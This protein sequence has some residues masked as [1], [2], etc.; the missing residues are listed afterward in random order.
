MTRDSITPRIALAAALCAFAI[1][2]AAEPEHTF[3]AT[4][5]EKKPF[6]FGGYAQ[7]RLE[8]IRL[9][10]DAPFYQLNNYGRPERATLTRNTATLELYG[11]LRHGDGTFD[12]RTHSTRTR[13]AYVHDEQHT[14]YEASY[15][16]RASPGLAFDVGKRVLRWGKGYA[17]NPVG[18]VERPKDPNDPELAREGYWLASADYILNPGGALQTLAFT[19][20]L[21]P[22]TADMNG[23]FGARDHL[24]PAAKLY[25]LYRDTDIDL[26]WQGQGSRPGRYG[27]DFSRNLTSNFEVHGEWARISGATR[28]LT[29]S[30]GRVTTQVSDAASHLLGIRYLTESN[31]TLI[32]EYYRNG[33]GYTESEARDYYRFVDHAFAQRAATGNDSLVQR[34]R[35]LSTGSYGRP[36]AGERYAYLRVQQ[37]DAWGIVYFQPGLTAMRNLDDGSWQLTPELLYTGYANV[38]LRARLYLLNGERHTDFGAK[39]NGRRLELQARLYF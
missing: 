37:K 18:F 23:D 38:E 31:T 15:G 27:F 29:D 13:D 20:V 30:V 8:D 32:A 33:T 4:D 19:P 21:L 3:D 11:K 34:A 16:H 12:V 39:Q 9:R 7:L 5:F 36:N 6:E 35:A 17:W 24:N 14:L 22:V 1:A 10:P 2:Q 28:R 25:L 26:L